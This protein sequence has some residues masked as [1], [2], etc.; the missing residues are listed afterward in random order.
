MQATGL[1]RVENFLGTEV[2][3]RAFAQA[4]LEPLQNQLQ[5]G[6]DILGPDSA[7]AI[8][9]LFS[10]L[11]GFGSIQASPFGIIGFGTTGL[12]A[13]PAPDTLPDLFGDPNVVGFAPASLV[14]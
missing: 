14:G 5:T 10:R 4:E 13:A 12:A 6:L 9:A 3:V 7:G 1:A 2:V 11:G 8:V